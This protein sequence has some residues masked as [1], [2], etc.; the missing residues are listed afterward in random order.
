MR[1]R[2]AAECG[3]EEEGVAFKCVLS[4]QATRPQSRWTPGPARPLFLDHDEAKCSDNIPWELA[5]KHDGTAF[6]VRLVTVHLFVH[7][8]K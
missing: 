4:R 1:L 3:R 6:S 8:L 5:T 2:E 7:S